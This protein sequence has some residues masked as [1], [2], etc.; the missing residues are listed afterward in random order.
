MCSRRL[1]L[2]RNGSRKEVRVEGLRS[3][4]EA[5]AEEMMRAILRAAEEW[6]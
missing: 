6:R 5:F 3:D 2:V 1:F 4:P